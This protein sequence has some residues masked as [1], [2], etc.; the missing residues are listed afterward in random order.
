MDALLTIASYESMANSSSW[1]PNEVREDREHT[2]PT[3]N[4]I[5]PEG[6]ALIDFFRAQGREV[7]LRGRIPAKVHATPVNT[8]P[9]PRQPTAIELA[10]GSD[11]QLYVCP[12]DPE[13]PHAEMMH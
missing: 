10:D 4:D 2:S 12:A 6:Q 13:H 8:H 7:Q 1:I 3:S 11:Q 9:A 5:G